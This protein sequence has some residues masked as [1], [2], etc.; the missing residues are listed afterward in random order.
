MKAR[1]RGRQGYIQRP[2]YIMVKLLIL[3]PEVCLRW[4]PCH[5]SQLACLLLAYKQKSPVEFEGRGWGEVGG[6]EEGRREEGG[7]REREGR[8]GEQIC[9]CNHFC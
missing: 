2:H 8:E 9:S 1:E 7:G 5:F 4:Q 6:R 3:P